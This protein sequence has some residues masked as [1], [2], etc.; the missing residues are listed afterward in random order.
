M[1][2]EYLNAFIMPEQVM[3]EITRD[4]AEKIFKPCWKHEVDCYS[5]L[6]GIENVEL[7]TDPLKYGILIGTAEELAERSKQEL[8]QYDSDD[9]LPDLIK[10]AKYPKRPLRVSE[11]LARLQ[12]IFDKHPD[13]DEYIV[14]IVYPD[15]RV[16]VMECG[17][18]WKASTPAKAEKKAA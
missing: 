17:G 16:L 1:R 15:P 4:M 2:S 5:E 13:R 8:A 7:I 12:K 6:H 9:P 3:I 11:E 10:L 18:P 14:N